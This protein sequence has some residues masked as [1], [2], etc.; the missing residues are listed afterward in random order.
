[1]SNKNKLQQFADMEEFNHVF[2]APW[3]IIK[4]GDFKMKSKWNSF[5]NNKKP[6]TV[7]FGCG[8]GEYTVGMAQQ[9]SNNNYIGVD[10]KGA[11]M[12]RGATISEKEKLKNVAFL[13]TRIDFT[14]KVFEK[15]EIS[16]IWITFPDPQR[17]KRRK[18]LTNLEFMKK[19]QQILKPNAIIHLKTDSR[20][21]YYYTLEFA[22]ANNFEI[23]INTDDLYASEY[24]N[25]KLEIKTFYEKI[26]LNEGKKINY[27]K[28]KIH[29]KELI[30]TE[31]TESDI[32]IKAE[33][34]I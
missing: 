16:E 24:V 8:K 32:K 29:D 20:I 30:D 23:L 17:K 19:Y 15:N 11:R 5:F 14:E 13:R 1:M 2:H 25:E 18:R 21:M 22:K 6:I 9:D 12:W 34:I 7:E 33:G 10:I 31:L 26:F 27:L 28:F 3:N 4:D